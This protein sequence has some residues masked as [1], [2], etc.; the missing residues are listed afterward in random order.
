MQDYKVQLRHPETE[1]LFYKDSGDLHLHKTLRSI[2]MI[3]PKDS[4]FGV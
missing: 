1:P 2:L 3:P 4:I